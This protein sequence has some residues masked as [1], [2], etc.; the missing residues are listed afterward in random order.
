VHPTARAPTPYEDPLARIDWDAVD[1]EC[2][3][4]PPDALSLAGVAAFEALPIDARRRLSHCEYLHLL[5]T[6]L[7]LE[8]LFVERLALLA[9]RTDDLDRRTA[10]LAEMREEAGHSLMF[11]ELIRRSGVALRPA[12]G[13]AVRWGHALGRAIPAE[14]ALFWAL[15]VIGEELPNRLNLRLRRGVEDATLSAVVYRMAQIH[16]RDEALHAAFARSQCEARTRRLAP[17][18][19]ALVSRALA[20]LLH[21]FARHLHYPPAAIYESAGLAP[22]ARWRAAALRN[23]VRRALCEETI[24]PTQEFLRRLGWRI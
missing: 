11:V 9:Y 15:V 22:G 10:Y 23:P 13:G 4:L 6:G 21:A 18:H 14:S 3:W 2:W 24:A 5:Q 8:A 7:W 17:W 20:L 19:R 12:R 1:R 16:V